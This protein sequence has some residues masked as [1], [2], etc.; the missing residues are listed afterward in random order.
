MLSKD[1]RVVPKPQKIS[2]LTST[3]R[4]HT[5]WWF[6]P[7]RTHGKPVCLLVLL[8]HCLY[9]LFPPL[10]FPHSSCW[11]TLLAEIWQLLAFCVPVSVRFRVYQCQGCTV[12][13]WVSSPCSGLPPFL[14]LVNSTRS[15]WKGGYLLCEI[16]G[17]GKPYSI[18][19]KLAIS[20]K[21]I[22]LGLGIHT[23]QSSHNQTN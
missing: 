11:A 22:N 3:Y 14:I 21:K 16:K 4:D 7:S 15:Q 10:K 2:H 5:N 12:A 6:N 9:W 17:K 13:S 19:L 18:S 8:S 1:Q 20:R 23:Q